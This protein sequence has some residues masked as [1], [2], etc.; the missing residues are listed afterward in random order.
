MSSSRT[1]PD[2]TI[3]LRLNSTERGPIPLQNKNGIPEQWHYDSYCA[4]EALATDYIDVMLHQPDA[5][6]RRGDVALS[7]HMSGAL[8]Q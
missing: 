7:E 5:L 4:L 1:V 6:V 3:A 2:P 8:C